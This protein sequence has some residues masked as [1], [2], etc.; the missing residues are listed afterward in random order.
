MLRREGGEE[1]TAEVLR[2][3]AEVARNNRGVT[4]QSTWGID[5]EGYGRWR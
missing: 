3:T 2:G 5:E 1:T 4:R